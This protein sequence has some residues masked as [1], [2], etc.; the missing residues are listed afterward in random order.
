MNQAPSALAFTSLDEAVAVLPGIIRTLP[1]N[2]QPQVKVL[3]DALLATAIREQV[4][5]EPRVPPFDLSRVS[6]LKHKPLSLLSPADSQYMLRA[7]VS[8]LAA[9]LM[10]KLENDKNCLA[11]EGYTQVIR[12]LLSIYEISPEMIVDEAVAT[13][14]ILNTL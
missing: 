9:T 6:E 4:A 14:K 13:A 3:T 7:T 2:C 12:S 11:G 1:A 10:V 5:S 8:Y